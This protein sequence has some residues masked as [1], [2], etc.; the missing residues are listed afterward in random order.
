MGLI[1]TSTP[2]LCGQGFGPR[3]QRFE[4]RIGVGQKLRRSLVGGH[5]LFERRRAIREPLD[6]L[7][8]ARQDLV[9]GR[10]RIRAQ[11]TV[12]ATRPRMPFT[13]RPASSPEKVFASSIDSLIAAFVGTRRSIVIS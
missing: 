1:G 11:V 12:A 2:Q 4:A 10:L 5:Q 9:K 6:S 3:L 8:E 7:F 13:N